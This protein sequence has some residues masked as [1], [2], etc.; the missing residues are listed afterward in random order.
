MASIN[1]QDFE[2]SQATITGKKNPVVQIL[3]AR[4]RYKVNPETRQRTEEL[5]GCAV[6]IAARYKLQTVK[7]PLA[8]K[9]TVEEIITAL[10]NKKIVTANF[11]KT[12]STLRG[13]CYALINGGQLIQGV[14]ATATEINI[15]S[16]DEPE[17]ED[18]ED[19]DV[20]FGG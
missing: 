19:M 16:I 13:K 14:S 8:T 6:D 15:V 9:T 7:L 5:E 20:D 12:A 3:G 4:L 11:G 1:F 2:I 10:E 17:T 18:F